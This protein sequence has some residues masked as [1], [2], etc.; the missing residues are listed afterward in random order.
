MCAGYHGPE[1]RLPRPLAWKRALG[2]PLPSLPPIPSPKLVPR[3]S[4]KETVCTR[5][6]RL[7]LCFGGTPTRTRAARARVWVG[8]RPVPPPR[9]QRPLLPPHSAKD[10]AEGATPVRGPLSLTPGPAHSPE[11]ETKGSLTHAKCSGPGTPCRVHLWGRAWGMP[12]P[13]EHWGLMPVS[14]LWPAPHQP[15]LL[16]WPLRNLGRTGSGLRL[17]LLAQGVKVVP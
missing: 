9:G 14:L 5:S 12:P 4:P 13:W 17:S 1:S 15:Q 11:Q 6:P 8:Y 3:L 10:R 2:W 7:G 16:A